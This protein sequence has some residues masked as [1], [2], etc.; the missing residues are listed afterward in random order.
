MGGRRTKG[1]RRPGSVVAALESSLTRSAKMLLVLLVE[2]GAAAY[3]APLLVQ[4]TESD[5]GF[6]WRVAATPIAASRLPLCLAEDRVLR[7]TIDRESAQEGESLITENSPTMLLSSAGG[8]AIERGAVISAQSAMISAIQFVDTW[9]NYLYRFTSA[10]RDTA[11]YSDRIIVID[12]TAIA[13]ASEEGLPREKL[14][15]CGHP[16]WEQI[17]LLPPTGSRDT[18][19][20]GGPVRRDYGDSLGYTEET[21]WNMVRELQVQRPDL[22]ENLYYA[23][24]PEQRNLQGVDVDCVVTYRADMLRHEIGQVLGIFS[25]PLTDAY[26]AGRRV[27]SIQPGAIGVD[28]YP[29]SRF[30]FVPRAT[31]MDD[32]IAAL[33]MT[34]ELDGRLHRSLKN[35]CQRLSDFLTEF[36]LN[37]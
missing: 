33:E 12:E 31:T 13:E 5:P 37:G 17:A 15:P 32:L 4:W 26:L 16:A 28:K 20:I 19:F 25:A 3:I 36:Y 9:T 21:C 7:R 35:S 29:L 24:H 27:I 34:P 6:D 22:I 2:A 10:G 18:V 1:D 23:P 8:W 30:G 11:H 14:V